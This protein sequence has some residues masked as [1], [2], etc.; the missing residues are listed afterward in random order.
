MD[1]REREDLA[2]GQPF[3][4]AVIGG[5]I[6]GLSAAFA[7]KERA[8]QAKVALRCT[9]LEQSPRWGGKILTYRADGLVMEAGPDS[10]LAR[11]PAGVE[12]IRKLGVA[13]ELVGTQPRA[14]QS[15]ILHRGRLELIPPGTNLGIPTRL[16]AFANSRLLTW[17][18][19]LRALADLVLPVGAL[20][21]DL[22]VG[23]F[24]RRRLGHEMVDHVI[25]PLLAGIYAGRID[26]LSLMATFPQ[27]RQMLEQHGSLIRGAMHARRASAASWS[28]SAAAT[29][30]SATTSTDTASTDRAQHG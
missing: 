13:A 12:L 15:Y 23:E 20:P 16:T 11:K 28:S 29:S 24:M 14:H 25:E 19:K 17:R 30:T 10:L 3:H 4:V 9:V 1:Q 8:E 18:G 2:Q 21:E 27:F 22:T 26:R 7:L 6:T 5:G